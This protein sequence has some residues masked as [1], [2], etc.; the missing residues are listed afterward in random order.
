MALKTEPAKP[1]RTDMADAKKLTKLLEEMELQDKL[2]SNRK[3]T[4]A[5]LLLG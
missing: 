2:W 3:K 5:L 1:T 4:A